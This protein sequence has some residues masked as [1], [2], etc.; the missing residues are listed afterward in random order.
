ML[1]TIS[2][3]AS[4]EEAPLSTLLMNS[5]VTCYSKLTLTVRNVTISNEPVLTAAISMRSTLKMQ[6]GIGLMGIQKEAF[7]RLADGRAVERYWLEGKSIRM[8][9]LTYGATIQTIDYAG[10]DIVLGYDTLEGYVHGGS[11]QG[12]SIGRYANRIDAGRFTLNGQ[13]YDVG[14][15]ENGIGHLH[16]GK[17]GF[18]K[19]VWNAQIVQDTDEPSLM[20]TQVAED[21]EEGYP[22]TLRETVTYTVTAEDV[23]RI[24]YQ[25]VSDKDTVVNLTNHAYFNINGWD[26]GDILNVGLQIFA[27]AITPIDKRF[28]PTGELMP[29]EGTPFDFRQPKT[30]GQDIH[31]DH[32]QLKLAGG[33]DHNFVL[34]MTREFRHA[35]SAYSPAT[36]LRL[37]CYTDLPG[38][39]LYVAN[40]LNEP[41]GKGGKAL[42]PH[43]AF[44]LETQ[45]FPDSPNHPEFPSAVLKA[46]DVWTSVTE[47][48]LSK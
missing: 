40:M 9:V 47:Y 43:Q 27:D 1:V 5:M 37:D 14:C 6:K 4:N 8:A 24:S 20:L 7:G 48:R 45:F 12:A 13:H 19:K 16:G 10:K 22:G 31:A 25:A 42:Y 33:Y 23:I 15:N 28:V 41:G 39:Q 38:V 32:E 17:I 29:V 18:D 2:G 11:Y 34:G 21:G 35:V 46:G 26:G 30:I 44:C 36:G 3:A